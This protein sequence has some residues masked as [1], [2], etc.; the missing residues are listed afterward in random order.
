MYLTW[1]LPPHYRRNCGPDSTSTVEASME[2][3]AVFTL[4]GESVL[5]MVRC[6]FFI[7]SIFPLPPPLTWPYLLMIIL[8]KQNK[9]KDQQEILYQRIFEFSKLEAT[10]PIA[11]QAMYVLMTIQEWISKT[12]FALVCPSSLSP[13]LISSSDSTA[14]GT[15]GII[16][17]MIF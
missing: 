12:S 2:N 14:N 8:D 17:R 11:V 4:P 13:F 5:I 9:Q 10:R 16:V 6:P 7:F 3:L 15:N 1:T